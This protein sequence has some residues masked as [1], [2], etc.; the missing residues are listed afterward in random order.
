[1]TSQTKKF[2]EFSDIVGIQLEC[3]YETFG[4]S[5]LV[6]VDAL[7]T[8]SD[9][10][11]TTLVKCPTCGGT[12]TVPGAH[13]VQMGYDTKVKEFVRMLAQM[14][15]IEGNLGCSIRFELKDETAKP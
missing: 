5:L 8:L 15:N 7:V 10:N 13:P 6:S 11:N 14:R 2:I 9:P 1:M 3:K 12:W 4:V